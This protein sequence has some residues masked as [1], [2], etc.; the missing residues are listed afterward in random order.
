MRFSELDRG[1]GL[2]LAGVWRESL[3]R[4]NGIHP[5]HARRLLD[6]ASAEGVLRRSTEGSTTQT[7]FDDHVVHVL[8]TDSGL[9]V[10]IP[11]HLYSG[12]SL[13]PDKASVSLR[14]E[15]RNHE[16][17]ALPER[18]FPM[19]AITP[20]ALLRNSHAL[21]ALRS[22][23]QNRVIL[24]PLGDGDKA[25]E[26]ARFYLDTARRRA[27]EKLPRE[28]L[29]NEEV[30]KESRMGECFEELKALAERR[31]D[32]GVRQ[33]EFLHGLHLLAEEAIR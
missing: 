22:R 20:D 28:T 3:I 17:D 6:E 16:V 25:I 29:G 9:P 19:I 26:P 10:A 14:I 4:T 12:G 32:T 23:L 8:R 30:L 1:D 31:G 5:E 24:E 18:F 15:V 13:I 21:P 33:R 7:R 27:R 2:I 11:A